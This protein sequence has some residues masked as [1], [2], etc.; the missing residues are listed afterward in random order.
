LRLN[1]RDVG[2]KPLLEV[3]FHHFVTQRIP[4]DAQQAGRLGL[5]AGGL[6]ESTD[7][8]VALIISAVLG[9]AQ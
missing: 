7:Q 1:P 8:Q 2:E 3:E 4:G 6:L 5:V 9:Y